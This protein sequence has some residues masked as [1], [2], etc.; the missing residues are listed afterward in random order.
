MKQ[1]VSITP[2]IREV[3]WVDSPRDPNVEAKLLYELMLYLGM[4]DEA[5]AAS[6]ITSELRP[7]STIISVDLPNAKNALLVSDSATKLW[8]RVGIVLLSIGASVES[9]QESSGLYFVR[10]HDPD[11]K[12][13]KKGLERLKFWKDNKITEAVVYQISVTGDA[14]TSMVLVFD[15]NGKE[16][17]VDT[18]KRILAVLQEKLG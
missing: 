13:I 10:Y 3:R 1:Q 8:D 14:E 2:T 16:V 12:V 11:G 6:G 5:V 7:M 15:E 4:P 18:A 17:N 9:R